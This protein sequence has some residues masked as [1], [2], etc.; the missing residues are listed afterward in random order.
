MLSISGP[1]KL[2]AMEDFMRG[3]LER[4]SVIL[5]VDDNPANLGVLSDFLDDEGFE[6]L[7]AQDGE[8]A[9][10]KVN[11]EPPDLILLDIMMPGIDG[12]ETC[13][14]LKKNERT[15]EIP[16]IFMSA[17]SDPVD[18]VKGLSIGAVDYITKPFQQQEVLARVKLHLKL[19]SL[20]K[21]LAEQN[22]LLERRVEERTAELNRTIF[23][24]QQ[25]QVQLVQSEKMS[26]L[27]QLVAG[28]AHEINN[29]VNFIYG[30]LVYAKDYS[31]N[32]LEILQ[33]Y[34]AK[35]PQP[36][37]D[38]GNKIEAFELDFL[39]EDFPR[40][41][42]SMQVGAERIREIVMSLKKFSRTDE[43]DIKAVDIHDGLDSTLMILHN[44]IKAKSDRP[45]IR[46][47]K[48]YSNLPLVECYPGQLNQVFMNLLANAID[49]I[50]ESDARKT[51]D[52]LKANPGTIK[53]CTETM[54]SECV[55]ISIADN[56]MGMAEDVRSLIFNPFFTTKPV[57]KGTGMGLAISYS[58][59]VEKHGGELE[60][61]SE[62]GKGTQ[63]IIQIPIEQKVSNQ[64]SNKQ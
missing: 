14:R 28:I 59:V 36:D 32:I 50:E 9:I 55:R 45:E 53:I 57:G 62:L 23:D 10:A 39:M 63:F 30:N 61:F 22:Q 16:V 8:S 6:V 1:D 38:I 56:A 47:V 19:R 52:E 44:K 12:F 46:V 15:T 4:N 21:K 29:P 5:I 43:S 64:V 2:E 51:R 40:I 54:N 11:Y 3:E 42:N 18:K 7:V 33:L 26:S 13:R 20:A 17:L 48:N 25:A 27:G 31:K 34:Q 49:A 41:I 58:I 60:C 24:L 37:E 35:Y